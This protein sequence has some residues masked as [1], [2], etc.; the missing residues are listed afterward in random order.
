MAA[1]AAVVGSQTLCVINRYVSGLRKSR[2]ISSSRVGQTRVDA[3]HIRTQMQSPPGGAINTTTHTRT[4]STRDR[5]GVDRRTRGSTHRASRVI[6]NV[7][8]VVAV[9][10]ST[11]GLH[12][13]AETT[14]TTHA[15][16]HARLYDSS[17]GSYLCKLVSCRHPAGP[18]RTRFFRPGRHS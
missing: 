3:P 13:H 6:N 10:E 16:K 8:V 4:H 12:A 14:T 5:A 11:R 9:V 15:R 18:R 2:Q 7:V 1:A 17:G